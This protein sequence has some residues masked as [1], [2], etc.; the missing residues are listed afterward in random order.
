MS[1]KKSPVSIQINENLEIVE[2]YLVFN[3]P[4]YEQYP[5]N[6]S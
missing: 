1:P 4:V 2:D 3:E 5:F 6:K